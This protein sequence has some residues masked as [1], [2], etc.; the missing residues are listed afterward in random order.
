MADFCYGCAKDV[1]GVNPEWNDFND[2]VDE[3]EMLSVL[4]EGCGIIWVDHEGKRVDDG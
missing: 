1:L 4:C 3:G 2:I